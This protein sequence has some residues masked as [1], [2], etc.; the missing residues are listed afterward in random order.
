MMGIP[1]AAKLDAVNITKR[2]RER[3]TKGAKQSGKVTKYNVGVSSST[4]LLYVPT[5]NFQG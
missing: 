3:N 5:E 4:A 2:E 1:R